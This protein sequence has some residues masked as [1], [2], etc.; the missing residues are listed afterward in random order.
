MTMEQAGDVSKPVDFSRIQE[1]SEGD[2]EFEDELFTVFLEDCQDRIGRLKAAMEAG[3]WTD[4]RREAH[5][6]KGACANIGTTSMQD[7]ALTLE[8]VEDDKAPELCPALVGEM[9][10]E[11]SRVSHAI[12]TYLGN[13]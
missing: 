4:F 13:A 9:E 10:A 7:I 1:T 3:E 12:K 8:H 11:F 2:L 6:I 5:T